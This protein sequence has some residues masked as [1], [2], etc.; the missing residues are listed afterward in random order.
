MHVRAATES[1]LELLVE[2]N[3]RL[4]RETEGRELDA[5]RLGRGVRRQLA[6]PSRG[7]YWLAEHEGEPVGSLAVTREWSDWRDGWFWWIQ[8]VYVRA[9]ARRLG[10]YRA[11]HTGVR[12]R[13]LA[14]G[15]VCG[16]RLYVERQNAAAMQTYAAVGMSEAVYALWE[17]D[18]V[19]GAHG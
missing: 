16:L 4:A 9:E 3:Q 17:E 12:E 2:F 14:A 6:E 1:D 19:L 15:D 18:F 13:A 7:E 10:V 5:A 8:S 11:L